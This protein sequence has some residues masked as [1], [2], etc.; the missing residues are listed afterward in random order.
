MPHMNRFYQAILSL[1]GT[2]KPIRR[3]QAP[4]LLRMLDVHKDDLVLDA[5]CGAG[6][7]TYEI[8]KVGRCIGIDTQIFDNF[9]Y[10]QKKMPSIMFQKANIEAIPFQ[11][12]F[13]DKIL[14]SSVIQMVEHDDLLLKE[15]HRVLKENGICVISF[16]LNYV[17]LKKLY[18]HQ[19]YLK[20]Q[21]HSNGKG[22][23]NL[24]DFLKMLNINHFRVLEI[25]FAPKMLGSKIS[26]LWLYICIKLGLP[27][28]HP[29]YHFVLYPLMY[30]DKY[31]NKHTR[32]NEVI[33]KVLKVRN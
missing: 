3:I 16:P 17:Y 26:E 12:K 22:Y 4:I 2:L 1:F 9:S 15:T 19:N 32:G 10:L 31:Q 24:I 28:T 30:F 13:F 29:L 11:D 7:L 21:Y 23:Y 5:G 25:E 18:N 6:I 27:I 20:K 14:L 8:G 33:L